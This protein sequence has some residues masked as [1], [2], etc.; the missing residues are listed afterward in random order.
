MSSGFVDGALARVTLK[1]I[2]ETSDRVYHTLSV[3]YR[4]VGELRL[5]SRPCSPTDRENI[6]SLQGKD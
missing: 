2:S 1:V 4:F 5:G 6:V 3:T